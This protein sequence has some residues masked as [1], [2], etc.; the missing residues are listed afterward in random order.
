MDK[1]LF[2]PLLI[3]TKFLKIF[4]LW[5]NKKSSNWY[6]IY[7]ILINL[8]FI[9]LYTFLT[10][11]Y[12][13]RVKNITNLAQVLSFLPIYSTLVVLSINFMI[14]V[15]EIEEIIAM[16]EDCVK[17]SDSSDIVRKNLTEIDRIFKVF[18]TNALVF[19]LLSDFITISTHFIYIPVWFP[20]DLDSQ[21]KFWISA[22]YQMFDI[23]FF[24]GKKSLKL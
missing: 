12:L 15:D 17:K 19:C 23:T 7:G 20:Y 8:I 6:K 11:M 14:R 10:A 9:Q 22:T 2:A 21:F 5:T 16:I 18:W 13:P 3:P 24:S 4:G 1:E